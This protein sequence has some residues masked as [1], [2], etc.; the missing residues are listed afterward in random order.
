[1][2]GAGGEKTKTNQE[3]AGNE[4]NSCITSNAPSSKLHNIKK[5]EPGPSSQHQNPSRHRG[6]SAEPAEPCP[7][8][9]LLFI[10][11]LCH[12]SPPSLGCLLPKSSA[13][14]WVRRQWG[15]VG[16]EGSGARWR[17]TPATPPA[18]ELH[19]E[20]FGDPRSSDHSFFPLCFAAEE[21]RG[22]GAKPRVPAGEVCRRS[23]PPPT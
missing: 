3:E 1:M 12:A 16:N 5:R 10:F 23:L 21:P 13:A 8:P 4:S 18:S 20:S 15:A 2:V 19:T 17:R 11:S 9:A 6:G 7:R 22:D 14:L